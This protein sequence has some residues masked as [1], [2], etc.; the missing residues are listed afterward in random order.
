M[1]GTNNMKKIPNDL[2][3]TDIFK[4]DWEFKDMIRVIDWNERRY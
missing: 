1:L 3:S 2:E 4:D